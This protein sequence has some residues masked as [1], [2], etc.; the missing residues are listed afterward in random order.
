VPQF[1]RVTGDSRDNG[2]PMINP[3]GYVSLH[4]CVPLGSVSPAPHSITAQGNH[5]GGTDVAGRLPDRMPP[6]KEDCLK[7]K[8]RKTFKFTAE[9]AVHAL[10]ILI[11][12][13]K[14][15]AKDVAHALKRREGLIKELR[16]KLAALEHGVAAGMADARK[17]VTGRAGKRSRR[18]VS[19]ARRAAMKLHGKYLG[20]VRPLSKQNRARVK[21][22]REAKGVR[23]AI[24]AAKRM[25]N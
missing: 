21:K 7:R 10:H 19:A 25:G 18:R 20:T 5:A 1:L 15:A 11:G 23:T 4:E 3:Q 9:H 13:G 2:L 14:L 22:I 16:T 24:A 17:A 6:F 12:D 8:T